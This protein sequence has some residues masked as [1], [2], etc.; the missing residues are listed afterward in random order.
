MSRI[1]N[2][3]KHLIRI[4]SKIR[5]P[6]NVGKVW[7]ALGRRGSL[8]PWSLRLLVAQLPALCGKHTAGL[9]RLFKLLASVRTML[10]NINKGQR[11]GTTWIWNLKPPCF[12][13]HG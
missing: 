3:L 6:N 7:G 9:N 5:I 4:Q 12:T 8:V 2:K 11:S 13:P 1:R 10:D